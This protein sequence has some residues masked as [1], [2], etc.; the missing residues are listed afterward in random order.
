MKIATFSHDHLRPSA[1]N[2]TRVCMKT[3]EQFSDIFRVTEMAVSER[4]RKPI[5]D[6][7]HNLGSVQKAGNWLPHELRE[8]QLKNSKTICNLLLEQC[9]RKSFSHRI[10]TG[11]KKW[12]YY[13]NPK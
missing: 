10:V 11:K 12:V 2:C 9:R 7:V 5:Q 13:K 3:L 4:L 6:Y 8:R 1:A